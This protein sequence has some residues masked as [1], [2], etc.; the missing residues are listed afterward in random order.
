[1]SELLYYEVMTELDSL[2]FKQV[3][4]DHKILEI[5]WIE[6]LNFLLKGDDEDDG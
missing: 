4:M 6:S 2:G 5:E 3:P 1:M